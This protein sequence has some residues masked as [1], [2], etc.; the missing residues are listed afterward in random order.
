MFDK[1]K[2]IKI[3]DRA[4][5]TILRHDFLFQHSAQKIADIILERKDIPK[6]SALELGARH[7]ALTKHLMQIV[8][9]LTAVEISP[10]L[11]ALNPCNNKILCD[12]ELLIVQ[13]SS[14]DL[15]ASCL[16]THW[17]NDVVSMIF[18]AKSWLRN[19]GAIV[20]SM[21]GQDSL[22]NVRNM[23]I[24][25]ELQHGSSRP[26]IIPFVKTKDITQILHKCGLRNIIVENDRFELVYKNIYQMIIDIRRMG[27]S[28]A[29][30]ESYMSKN[31]GLSL[32]K[33][34]DIIN[35]HV[36]IITFIGFK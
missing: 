17:I 23:L 6:G 35:T 5:N 24:N 4:S 30:Y 29:L 15:I 28:S 12:Q 20:M 9:N 19:G 16:D 11:L 2:L 33:H 36:D 26:H 31:I 27:E 13:D 32:I 34:D 8:N 25:M 7:G 18:K 1:S 21:I 10:H 22:K 14:Y 3:R